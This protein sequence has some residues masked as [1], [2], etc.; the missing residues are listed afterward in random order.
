[1]FN[2]VRPECR[3]VIH[4]F[5][6][7]R[8]QTF[9][10][11]TCRAGEADAKNL[12]EI[13]GW[14]PPQQFSSYNYR[15]Q[16]RVQEIARLMLLYTPDVLYKH[17]LQALVEKMD[18]YSE[19]D[20]LQA[21]FKSNFQ[22]ACRSGLMDVFHC[23]ARASDRPTR[24]LEDFE[25]ECLAGIHTLAEKR[26]FCREWMKRDMAYGHSFTFCE[27]MQSYGRP[28]KLFL[29]GELFEILTSMMNTHH[30]NG[31]VSNYFNRRNPPC[32]FLSKKENNTL[33]ILSEVKRRLRY[34]NY[35]NQEIEHSTCSSYLN[36]HKEL[37]AIATGLILEAWAQ[38]I[39][40]RFKAQDPRENSGYLKMLKKMKAMKENPSAHREMSLMLDWL[41]RLEWTMRSKPVDFKEWFDTS[42]LCSCALCLKSPELRQELDKCLASFDR[43]IY[44]ELAP[45]AELFEGR[46]EFTKLLRFVLASLEIRTPEDKQI[47]KDF[48]QKT[49]TMKKKGKCFF[50]DIKRFQ[51]LIKTLIALQTETK[52]RPQIK[53]DV[54]KTL[55]SYDMASI[56]GGLQSVQFALQYCPEK[57][58]GN[59]KLIEDELR[60]ILKLDAAANPSQVFYEAF[61]QHCREYPFAVLTY[62]GSLKKVD[63]E[64]RGSGQ[65]SRVASFLEEFVEPTIKGTFRDRL[66]DPTRRPKGS[67][68][69]SHLEYLL[70]IN[71]DFLKIWVPKENDPGVSLSDLLPPVAAYEKGED[72]GR[73]VNLKSHRVVVTDNRFDKLL[74]GNIPGSCLNLEGSPIQNQ[75]LLGYLLHGHNLLIEVKD[76]RGKICARG[77]LRALLNESRTK[78]T[79]YLTRLYPHKLHSAFQKGIFLKAQELATALGAPLVRGGIDPVD[80]ELIAEPGIAPIEQYDVG[81]VA[82]VHAERG[83]IRI[84]KSPVE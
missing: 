70:K 73:Y 72:G 35:R 84:E 28:K 64:L 79:L 16:E 25:D 11:W 26:L 32:Q 53:F 27:Y 9:L 77:V 57:L 18:R 51:F 15:L 17:G 50:W 62:L 56:M 29:P 65:P 1:M 52:G 58:T 40:M 54:L 34:E 63:W 74:C 39:A 36:Q 75:G 82:N 19:H 33:F 76:P 14:V 22:R 67:L 81:R 31:A 6:N 60:D 38:E 48:L 45:D 13:Q 78:M 43:P 2:L 71:P 49:M 80:E 21:C 66:Y 41:T 42:G 12:A 3:I 20:I 30:D 7:E 8:E 68:E 4:S 5:L 23:S 55:T 61:G 47:V 46:Y 44:D 10:R 37:D 69:P 24:F 59:F 83:A